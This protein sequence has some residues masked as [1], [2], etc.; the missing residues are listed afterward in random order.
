MLL[1]PEDLRK[2]KPDFVPRLTTW[3][4]AR[5]SVVD[6]CDGRRTLAAIEKEVYKRHPNLFASPAE[7][8]AFVA[9]VMVPYAY[10]DRDF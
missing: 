5:R 8:A 4:E 6:L 3:G 7:A 9:E 2:A 10:E 1:C